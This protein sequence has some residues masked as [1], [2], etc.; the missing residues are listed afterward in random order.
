[1]TILQEISNSY[2]V[3]LVLGLP[4]G[5]TF[6]ASSGPPYI[7]SYIAG[8]GSVFRKRVAITTA[9]NGGRIVAYGIN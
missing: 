3:A 2:L 5:L 8:I 7:V 1:M 9:Y 4:Y 6:C